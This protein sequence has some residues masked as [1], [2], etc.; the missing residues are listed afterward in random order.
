MASR[1]AQIRAKVMCCMPTINV[2]TADTL[3]HQDPLTQTTRVATHGKRAAPLFDQ[4]PQEGGDRPILTRVWYG[5]EVNHVLF[6]IMHLLGHIFLCNG[7]EVLLSDKS[8]I[9]LLSKLLNITDF[10]HYGSHLGHHLCLTNVNAKTVEL[11]ALRV[12]L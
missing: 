10:P 3:N 1:L 4:V 2:S 8:I 11:K 9:S 6:L 12:N 5:T 7:L